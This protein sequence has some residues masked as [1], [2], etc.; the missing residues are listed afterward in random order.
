VDL[1]G[2][3]GMPKI[4]RDTM[5]DV[6]SGSVI[7]LKRGEIYTVDNTDAAATRAFDRSLTIMSGPDFNPQFARIHL[8]SNYNFVASSTV[9]S[10]VFRDIIFKGV[11]ANGAS[12]DNDYIINANVVTNVG[13]IRLDNCKISRLRGTVRLQTASTGAHVTDYY[14]N[15]CVV[16]SIR[17]F[18][19]VMASAASNFANVRI[20]N[21]TFYRCRRYVNHGVAG[22]NLLSIDNCTFNEV[23]TGGPTGAPT[24]Y[25]IDFNTFGST[26]EIKNSII[27]KTWIETAGNTD[28]GGIRSS[29]SAT[30]TVTNSY[31]L[32]DFV[33]T[34]ATFQIPGITGYPKPST[35]VYTDPANGNFTI[36]DL[37]FPGASSAG[38]PR[39]R[40]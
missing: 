30:I 7:W 20:T 27:G 8:T 25:L 28:V 32:S 35:D 24:N 39:W 34:V 17:E 36:K 21:S 14:V 18:A 15:N 23:P 26:I 19:V 10:I 29:A 37:A 38:D 5:L 12:F 22:N 33:S 4:L 16:D 6:P 11:R 13:K 40:P 1:R 9:D 3:T 2:I 31:S